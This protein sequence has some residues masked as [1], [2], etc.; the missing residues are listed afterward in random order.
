VGVVPPGTAGYYL[1][2][3]GAGAPTWA[4]T[5]NVE[6]SSA[7]NLAG[8][9]AGSFP[10]QS[11][12]NTTS[13]LPAGTA[14]YILQTNG[15][16]A[17]T[18]TNT[19]A[20]VGTNFT[21]IPWAG[22]TKTGSSLADLATKSASDLNSGTLALARG[23]TGANLAAT[24]GANQVVRQNSAGGIFTVSALDDSDVPDTITING[25]NN[26][27]WVS[28]SKTGSSLADLAT[29]SAS[30]LNS[31]TLA[32]DRGGTGANLAATGGANQFVRQNSLGGGFTVSAITDADVPDNITISGLGNISWSSVSKVGSSLADLATKSASDLNSGTLALARGGTGSNLAA[33]GGANQ[34]VKQTAAGGAL[35]VSGIVDADVPNNITIDTANTA[36][37]AP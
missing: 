20:L 15:A 5:S 33:T 24:G 8:G 9:A 22:V 16:A 30:D 3:N 12:P 17:P 35:S 6:V 21:A 26:V 14:G 29:K 31:G 34:F 13:M 37:Y 2:S 4:T 1:K 25:T 28:V 32:L 23:G 7:S 19:P 11:A 36:Y 27:T 10:W 18:W